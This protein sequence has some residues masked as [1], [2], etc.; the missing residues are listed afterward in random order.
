MSDTG[1]WKRFW[2]EKSASGVS[3]YEFD[4]LT[5]VRDVENDRRAAKE[6]LEL[7]DPRPTDVVFDAGCGT[8]ANIALLYRRV[9]R[10]VGMDYIRTALVRAQER[11]SR[12]GITD[13]ELFEGNVAKIPVPDDSFDVILCVSVLH[14][15][16]DG[17]VRSALREFARMSRDGGRLILHVKNLASLYLATLRL[18]KRVLSA[19]GKKVRLDHYRTFAW[20]LRELKEAG[21]SVSQY[22]SG[23]LFILEGMPSKLVASLQAMELRYRNRFPFRLSFFKRHGADLW[24]RADYSARQHS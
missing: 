14:Y 21:F 4:R 9:A 18:A 22:H 8:G 15:L 3:N 17:E 10:I 20:Y 16:D 19:L 5:A 24:M 2:E 11:F 6:F 12:E 1:D 23:N 13:V 7:V